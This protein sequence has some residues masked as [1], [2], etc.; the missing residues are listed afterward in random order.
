MVVI[1]N[2]IL[3]GKVEDSNSPFL[4]RALRA[5]GVSLERVI[6]IPEAVRRYRRTWPGRCRIRVDRLMRAQR[7]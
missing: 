6:V 2:E 7:S 1:G 5:A 4:A 3:S